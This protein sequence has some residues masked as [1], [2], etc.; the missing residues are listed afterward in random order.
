MFAH[1]RSAPVVVDEDEDL[2]PLVSNSGAVYEHGTKGLSKV[3]I[4]RRDG[5][6][7]L[8]TEVRG[9]LE[10]GSGCGLSSSR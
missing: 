1:V 7:F 10:R 2:P 4:S 5:T 6:E 8:M 9:V 3:D